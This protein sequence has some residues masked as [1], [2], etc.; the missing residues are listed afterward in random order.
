MS[1]TALPRPLHAARDGIQQPSGR[2]LWLLSLFAL[3][4]VYGDIGTSPLY[5]MSECFSGE[6]GVAGDK[7][8]NILGILSLITWSLIIAISVKYL[9]FILRADNQGEG[10]ILALSALVTEGR[11]L[12]TTRILTVIGLIGAAFLYSDGIITP[13]ISV[14]SAI[15]GLQVAAPA[16]TP[17]VLPLTSL[18]IVVLFVFQYRGS[19]RIG[20]IFGPVMILYFVV[21]ALLGITSIVRDPLILTS[22][23]PR[24]AVHFLYYHGMHGYLVLGA[25]FLAV[26][27]GEALYADLG[28]FG[29]RPIRL[30][31]FALV[32]PALLLNYYGQG[33]LL[34]RDVSVHNPYFQLAPEWGQIP[35]VVLSSAAAVIASQA[36][37]SGTFSLTAQA[38]QLGY[39]PRM[40]I[41]HTSEQA[42]GQIY[43]PAIN[44]MMMIMCLGLVVA[45][46]SST[47]LAA[48]YGVAIAT[49]MTITSL[50]FYFVARYTWHWAWPLAAGTTGLFLILDVTFFGANIAK[51]AHGGWF[52]IVITT[53]ILI[54]MMTWKNG[55]MSLGQR[56]KRSALP[57]QHLLADLDKGLPLRVAG[58]AVFMTG[59]P[60]LT[61]GSLL[62]NLKHNHVLHE[63]VFVL[64]VHTERIPYVAE[65]NRCRIIEHRHGFYNVIMSFGFNEQPNVPAIFAASPGGLLI[66]PLET[67]YFLGR[68]TILLARVSAWPRWRRELFSWMSRNSLNAAAFFSLPPNRVV[69]LGM[70]VEI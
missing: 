36:V 41:R 26:T 13:A 58:T 65:E 61:P 38:M 16:L 70:Q 34:M 6:Y 57:L 60:A 69:E 22:V 49:T 19:A 62:H 55:R 68:E 18:L 31:W 52:P 45:F 43:V 50:L 24:H 56:L 32:L 28:H 12:R 63:R 7:A 46:G 14:L 48:A 39:C 44:W 10:G 25:V 15:E 47:N 67:S 54:M 9:S 53:I 66:K 3:G 1:T 23:D 20:I 5:T 2:R 33:A 37:I 11:S 35:L 64:T 42:F 40:A 8:A 4:V 29:R 59:D 21:L 27:G 17:Y 51:I 30:A